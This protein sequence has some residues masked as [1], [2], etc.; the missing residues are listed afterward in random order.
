MDQALGG[1]I[2]IPLQVAH[3]T[4]AVIDDAHDHRRD[5]LS[6]SGQHLTRAVVK[7]QVPQG[8]HMVDLKAAHLQTLQPVSRS[9]S[10][11]GSALGPGLAQHALGQEVAAHR[12]VRGHGGVTALEGG[13]QVVKVQLCA[14]AGVLA[15]LRHQG[16]DHR[17]RQTGE[18]GNIAAQAVLQDGHRVCCLARCVVPALQRADTECGVSSGGGVAP[19]LGGK[20]CQLTL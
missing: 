3:Q 8:T 11:G 15:V 18:A 6:R 19:G 10:P 14:P 7:V 2:E 17:L 20:Q 1:L 5:P 12:R 13:A 9:K 4:G 16:I